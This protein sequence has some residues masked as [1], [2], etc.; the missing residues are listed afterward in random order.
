MAYHDSMCLYQFVNN[1]PI[2]YGDP[3][4]LKVVVKNKDDISLVTAGQTTWLTN[5]VTATGNLSILGRKDWL[6]VLDAFNKD[7]KIDDEVKDKFKDAYYTAFTLQVQ[8]KVTKA[9]DKTPTDLKDVNVKRTIR[10]TQIWKESI[11]EKPPASKPGG[12]GGYS[13]EELAPDPIPDHELYKENGLVVVADSPGVT[14][15]IEKQKNDY[16][17]YD[18]YV[19]VEL[20]DGQNVVAYIEYEVHIESKDGKVQTNEVKEVKKGLGNN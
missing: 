7:Q 2:N 12:K 10:R 8:F 11:T 20:L 19:R 15:L 3:E 5:S 17:K 1:N 9:D 16:H 14:V 18:A 4:G 13:G 6:K